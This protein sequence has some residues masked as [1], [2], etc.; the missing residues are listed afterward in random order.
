MKRAF[1]SL[2]YKAPAET[3]EN[4]KNGRR[5]KVRAKHVR[6]RIAWPGPSL[7]YSLCN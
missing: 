3:A 4:G 7:P 2:N 6:V 1:A 5:I